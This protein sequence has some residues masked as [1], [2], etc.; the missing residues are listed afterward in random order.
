MS[1]IVSR[2]V[3]GAMC[4]LGRPEI[5]QCSG[6]RPGG[7]DCWERAYESAAPQPS[8]VPPLALHEAFDFFDAVW[9]IRFGAGLIGKVPTATVATLAEPVSDRDDFKARM[10]ELADVLAALDAGIAV[11]A[12]SREVRGSLA[13]IAAALAAA[14]IED[15]RDPIEHLRSVV[16]IRTAL[17]HAER[18]GELATRLEDLGVPVAPIDWAQAWRAVAS[19]TVEALRAL[20]SLVR[21]TNTP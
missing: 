3:A 13:R 8:E 17:Q 12:E 11:P 10:S 6:C 18:S 16:A 20:R 1:G 19:V 15:A 14:G 9:T 21:E 5:R 4:E 2:D 7:H